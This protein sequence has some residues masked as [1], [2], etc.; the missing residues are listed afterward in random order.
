MH[1]LQHGFFST[2]SYRNVRSSRPGL[3]ISSSR[4]LS[5]ER[6]VHAYHVGTNVL[7]IQI[8]YVGE[9]KKKESTFIKN[10]TGVVPRSQRHRLV[11]VR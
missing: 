7:L 8:K 6:R 1:L 10:W 2:V 5:T 3:S 4:P 11:R 9:V